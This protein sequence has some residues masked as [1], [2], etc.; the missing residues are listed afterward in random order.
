MSKSAL[1]APTL[2][3]F[4]LML[5]LLWRLFDP[6][7]QLPIGIVLPGLCWYALVDVG[8]RGATL[9][10]C[11]T[12]G[13]TNGIVDKWDLLLPP[14]IYY[15]GSKWQNGSIQQRIWLF[16]KLPSTGTGW[17]P[18]YGV[19]CISGFCCGTLIV[20]QLNIFLALNE[21]HGWT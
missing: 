7:Q 17:Y 20:K 5:P 1:F 18:G 10:G 13:W 19:W 9:C 2:V 11:L 6:M 4:R 15:Y 3:P 21:I 14:L 8:K 16:L 12:L